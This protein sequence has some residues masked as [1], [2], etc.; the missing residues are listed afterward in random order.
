VYACWCKTSS[1]R[2]LKASP[3]RSLRP[4][5][6][7]SRASCSSALGAAIR[8]PHAIGPPLHIL[9]CRWLEVQKVKSSELCGLRVS[10]EKYV[11]PKAPLQCK[12]CQRFS[13]TQR[14]CGYAPRCVD[15]NPPG[16]ALPQGSSLNTAAAGVSTHQTTGAAQSGRRLRPRL[17]SGRQLLASQRTVRPV[18]RFQRKRPAPSLLRSRRA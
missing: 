6:S 8:T 9:W 13:H 1:G 11:A 4:W 3:G 16:S 7:V 5:E 12:R 15:R 2:C 10:V 14:N 18:A 17:Q